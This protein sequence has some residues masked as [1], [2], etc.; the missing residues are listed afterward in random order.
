MSSRH[1][2]FPRPFLALLILVAA[3]CAVAQNVKTRKRNIEALKGAEVSGGEFER[4]I[5]HVGR[6]RVYASQEYRA[7]RAGWETRLRKMVDSSG[8][9]LG[10]AFGLRLEVVDTRVWDAECDTES[11][12]DCLNEL[13]A[14]DA[15]EG[16]DWVVGL[17]SSVP[18]FT[19][20]F[21]ELGMAALP[22]RHFV[23]RDLFAAAERKAIN[24]SFDQMTAS[25][26]DDIFKQRLKHKRLVV[27]L[28][29]W[30]HTMGGLHSRRQD[31]ILYPAYNAD[32]AGFSE[33]NMA[34]IDA[35][36]VDR[37]PF[38]PY[39]PTLREYLANTKSGDWFAGERD[40]LLASLGGVGA[41]PVQN[42]EP[43][44]PQIA[45]AGDQDEIL[46]G[47]SLEDR[48]RYA[49]AKEQFDARDLEGSW[50]SLEPLLKRY[51]DSYPIQH[52]GCGLAMHVGA[53]QEAGEA[54]RRAIELAGS[55]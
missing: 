35:S 47:V 10:P 51:P 36:L 16:V 13:V 17:V 28:H 46:A 15:G 42:T 40:R 27:F 31:T 52:F 45:V 29:E 32:V 37:F 12:H 25:K 43:A 50:E 33:D 34:L 26:R 24:D 19:E 48:T 39:F 55:Q 11:L 21:D 14:L 44:P 54:C 2:R 18:R 23:L 1:S 30:A 5:E 8:Q 7:Q 3:G 53:R 9:V 22:G 6:I 38:D 49:K 4:P 20:S 41:H